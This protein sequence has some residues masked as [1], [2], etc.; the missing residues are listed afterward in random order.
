MIGARILLKLLT[1]AELAVAT[2]SLKQPQQKD[3]QQIQLISNLILA[4]HSYSF[5]ESLLTDI[6]GILKYHQ[7][8]VQ[9]TLQVE[10]MEYCL[11]TILRISLVDINQVLIIF[12]LD[13]TDQR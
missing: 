7:S 9:D 10:I 2:E 3:A 6:F 13:C 5:D 1:K 4:D 8:A 12:E 11:I